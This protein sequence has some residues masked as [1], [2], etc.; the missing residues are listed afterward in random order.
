MS[1]TL[2]LQEILVNAFDY[3]MSNIYTS[4]PG[5]IVGVHESLS[6]M[7]VDVQPTINIR[8]EDSTDNTPRPSILNVPLQMPVTLE[9]GL[10]YPIK[11]GNPVWLQFSMRG[12]DVWKR[13]TGVPDTPSDLRM[14]DIRDCIAV[15]GTY[16]LGMSP[17][18]SQSRTMAH[19][20]DDVV[21]VHNIG[22]ANEVEIRL[23]PSGDVYVNS[24]EK[25]Y[26]NCKDA[27]INAENSVEVTCEDYKVSCNSYAVSTINYSLVATGDSDNVFSQ[28]NFKMQGSFELNGVAMES[29]VHSGVLAGGEST[30]GPQN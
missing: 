28:G 9:G 5:I 4:I 22:R 20:P 27:E 21:L 6:G 17:N 19:S 11:K 1:R 14:F 25:V 18:S 29:H 8:N 2:G 13:G 10:T 30:Q 15:P 12:L 16:P 23:K 24:P 7:R 3:E 26:I